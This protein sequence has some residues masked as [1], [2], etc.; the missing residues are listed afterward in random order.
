MGYKLWDLEARKIVCNNDVF[1]NQDKMHK[2][3]ITIVEIRRVI[4]EED[5]HVHRGVPNAGQVGQN[6]PHVQE[7]V[8]GDKQA[9][10][11][12]HV[13]KQS[14]RVIRA[15]NW[16]VP[17]LDYVMLMDCKEPSCCKEAMLREDKLKW[18]KAMQSEMDSLHHNSTWEL[19]NLPTGKRALPCKWV[20]KLKVTAN[21][22]KPKYKA[23]LVSKGFRQQ[24]GVDFEE[25]FSLV[26]K[27]TTLHCVLALAAKEDMELV[28]MD[29]KTTF[30]H[31]DL[32][33]DIY[34]QQPEGFVEKGKENLVCK[35]KKSL[36]GLKQAPREW[37]HKFHSFMLSQG[38]KRSDIDNCL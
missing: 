21:E 25:I 13:V 16:Y 34:M 22:G 5:G 14:C 19:V 28:Q 24:Q 9:I 26:V 38:Y 20:Y 30:L 8:R 33:E 35:L 23:R 17:S 7:E 15:P 12:Q 11:A 36:Y 4:F 27:M 29:V 37:Y 3:A 6:A 32:H 18:E 10:E 31:G 1:F 2:K